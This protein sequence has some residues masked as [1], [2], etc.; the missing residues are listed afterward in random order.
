M[1]Y[2]LFSYIIFELTQH[3]LIYFLFC[4]GFYLH[5]YPLLWFNFLTF[6][7]FLICALCFGE[8][9][10]LGGILLPCL[11]FLLFCLFCCVLFDHIVQSQFILYEFFWYFIFLSTFLW[12]T[13]CVLILFKEEQ[14]QGEVKWIWPSNELEELLRL[15]T[16]NSHYFQY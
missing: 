14:S 3:L 4:F 10:V 8:L 7:F 9:E 11:M 2:Y 15:K 12:K 16:R 13:L 1:K 5:F 6:D